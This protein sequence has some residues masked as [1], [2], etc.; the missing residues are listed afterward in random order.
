[1]WDESHYSR[2]TVIGTLCAIVVATVTA[3]PVAGS[4]PGT[5]S[6]RD[7]RQNR[8]SPAGNGRPMGRSETYV[9]VVDRIVDGEHVVILLED[10]DEIVDQV[11]VAHEA[12]PFLEE[13]DV[14]C[15]ILVDG[16]VHRIR[17]LEERT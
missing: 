11:V 4:N 15:V 1:M 8:S 7:D 2:R 12:Y 14:V 5:E 16:D 9:G 13:R 6:G 10:G 17:P 3:L